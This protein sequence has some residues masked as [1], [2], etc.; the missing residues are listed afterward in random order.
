[1]GV[2]WLLGALIAYNA[3]VFGAGLPLDGVLAQ[4]TMLSGGQWIV[5]VGDAMIGA[6]L[7]L[8]L[9]AVGRATRPGGNTLLDHALA[10][11][12]LLLCLIEL[13]AVPAAATSVF[14]FVTLAALSDV[15]I[16]VLVTAR[17]GRPSPQAQM[18]APTGGKP[19]PRSE[20]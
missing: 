2:P 9:L 15:I 19:T 12:V 11:I 17:A 5:T 18:P 1:M 14:V 20:P 16:G 4:V 13:V 7:L 10:V 6:T 8:L 3:V